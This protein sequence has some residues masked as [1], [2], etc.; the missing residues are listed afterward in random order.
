[1]CRR[2]ALVVIGSA[3]APESE[4]DSAEKPQLDATSGSESESESESEIH[5]CE[6]VQ[7]VVHFDTDDGVTLEADV[8]TA[9]ASGGP[10]VVLLH[11]IPPGNDRS[12]Y[13]SDFIAA[14]NERGLTV[15]NLDRRGAGGSEG[16]P[17]EAFR[18]TNGA[19]DAKAA[20]DFLSTIQ[21]RPD[22]ARMAIVGASN[23]TTTA[24]DY[25]VLAA[26]AGLTAPA[27]L[28]FL[29]G[30]SYTEHQNSID[31]H[32][33]LLAPL[34]ILFEYA[35]NESEWAVQWIGVKDANWVFDERDVKSG[36]GT[37]MFKADP[38]SIEFVAEFIEKR[39]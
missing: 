34:P 37:H 32:S 30:G 6:V 5:V 13:P 15:L 36:H 22:M 11:M 24:L 19:L 33:E 29:T 26:T 31:D 3:C 18:G 25:T 8:W 10:A 2:L 1:M 27:A 21:C 4:T 20:V 28:V 38:L 7:E 17:K 12:N 39:L 14:L 16:D 23:G 35:S 9:G